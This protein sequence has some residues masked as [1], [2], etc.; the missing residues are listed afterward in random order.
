M[1]TSVVTAAGAEPGERPFP[2]ALRHVAV[3][4]EGRHVAAMKLLRETVGAA[5]RPD[6][7][8]GEPALVLQLGDQPVELV[9]GRDG[10]EGVLDLLM[11]E[12]LGRPGL[13]VG[14]AARVGAGELADLAVERGREEHRLPLFGQAAHEAVDLGLEAHVEHAVGFVE[15]EDPDPCER[16]EPALDEVLQAAGCRDQDVGSAGALRLA[17]DRRASVDGGDA[18]L[19]HLGERLELG[20]HLGGELARRNEHERGRLAVS[21]LGPLQDRQ[22]EGKGLA[23]AGRGLGQHVQAGE[24]VRKDKRL[25]REWDVDA[26]LLERPEISGLTPS[27]RNDCVDNCSTPLLRGSR[28]TDSERPK[29]ERE[30]P[31]SHGTARAVRA[32][33][34]AVERGRRKEVSALCWNPAR[35]ALASHLPVP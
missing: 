12:I 3:Q 33:T 25:D 9:L 28:V 15:H 5:L 14:R 34:V 24:R 31:V 21:G 30:K 13:E 29:E 8:Q 22:A 27:A 17:G 26:A 4:R 32:H 16:D 1:A 18:K 7:D 10:D 11:V 35:G 6:E 23:R 20:R 2:L 19:L